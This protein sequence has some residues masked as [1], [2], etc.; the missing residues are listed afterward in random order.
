MTLRPLPVDL[1]ALGY[2]KQGGR[3][4]ALLDRTAPWMYRLTDGELQREGK[5]DGKKTFTMERYA[6]ADVH[7]ADVGGSGD[8]F[9]SFL[10]A[11]GGFVLRL[12]A[13][14]V[15]SNAGRMTS[16]YFGGQNAVKRVAIP[17][18]AV[19]PKS[20]FEKLVFDAY[21]DDGIYF[22]SLGDVFVPRATGDNG[23]VI[24]LL[25]AGDEPLDVY[26]DDDSSGC[27]AG[28]NSDG[29]T[30]P[31]PCVGTKYDVKLP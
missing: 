17:L 26:V 15:T 24:E 6:Y 16:D 21:D 1:D 22:L 27:T 23:A 31:V 8:D 9:C 13:A 5:I 18:D 12:V 20:D 14:G 10:P 19:H 28:V 7:A 4:E 25:H 29:P 3:R 2:A 11:S 30:G